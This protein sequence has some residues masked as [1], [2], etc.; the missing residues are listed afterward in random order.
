MKAYVRVNMPSYVR[1]IYHLADGNRTLL[2]DNYYIDESKVNMVY[3]IPE[4]FE[5][6]AP[7]GAEFLQAFARTEPFG[8]LKTT[9]VDGYEIINENL[10]EFVPRMRGF[11]KLKKEVQQAE[12]L[13]VITTME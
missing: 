9:N 7:F 1:F 8:S 12:N 13:L 4:E 6:A 11:K 3:Q 2:L 5:C 10:N